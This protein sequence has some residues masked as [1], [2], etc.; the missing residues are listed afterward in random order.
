MR[1]HTKS[2]IQCGMTQA[3]EDTILNHKSENPLNDAEA[4]VIFPFFK[5]LVDMIWTTHIIHSVSDTTA[6]DIKSKTVSYVFTYMLP[7]F[8]ASRW[9]G[10][11]INF[12]SRSIRLY[13][14]MQL[15]LHQKTSKRMVSME[16]LCNEDGEEYNL[17]LD[18]TYLVNDAERDNLFGEEMEMF[19]EMIEWYEDKRISDIQRRILDATSSLLNGDAQFIYREN[20]NGEQGKAFLYGHIHS[21]M[22]LPPR[23]TNSYI[24]TTLRRL[25][26]RFAKKKYGTPFSWQSVRNST[27]TVYKH[28]QKQKAKSQ[29]SCPVAG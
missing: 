12:F 17:P 29:S 13:L 5:N 22:K 2:I 11:Y 27:V 19:N 21:M 24:G 10:N 1:K 26:F 25:F 28:I 23:Y 14:I 20:K 18:T 3:V 15:S 8:D 16:E 9:N 7:K 4:S 6:D